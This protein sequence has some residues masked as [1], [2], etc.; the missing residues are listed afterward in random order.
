MQVHCRSSCRGWNE[1][2][3]VFLFNPIGLNACYLSHAVAFVASA[4]AFYQGELSSTPSNSVCSR[5]S[6]ILYRA[7]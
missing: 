3:S 7:A 2:S 5:Q 1:I 6:A 4:Q